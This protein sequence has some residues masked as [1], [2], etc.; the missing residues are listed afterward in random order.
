[1]R[2]TIL[3]AK[4]HGA[5]VGA[6]P[7]FFERE[8]F[9]R[10]EI[11][12]PINEISALVQQQIAILHSIAAQHNVV[13]RHV[14]PH[15]ALYNMSAKDAVIAHAIALAVKNYDTSLVLFGLSGSHS[16]TE[17]QKLGLATKSEVFADRS[18]QD[19]GRL[20]PRTEKNALITNASEAVQ[21]VLQMVE[22]KKVKTT[23]GK[24]IPVVAET[25]CIHGDGAHA[26][27]FAKA[28]HEALNR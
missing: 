23:S 25:I 19:D 17:A 21:Q 6:H 28:I 22:E 12:L 5:G 4:K 13:L 14:K 15:G 11:I 1:M 20:T 7:S 2:D 10:T 24:L 27:E 9:G 3:L 16:I 8:N 18:Y 26:L